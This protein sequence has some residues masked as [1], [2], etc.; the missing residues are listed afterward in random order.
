[1]GCPVGSADGVWGRKTSRAVRVS[2][3]FFG[4]NFR[5]S[6]SSRAYGRQ[7]SK[8]FSTDHSICSCPPNKYLDWDGICKISTPV[9]PDDADVGGPTCGWFAL[10]VC[11]RQKREA[12]K[13]SNRYGG[14]TIF[15]Q[16]ARF[17]NFSAGYYCSVQGPTTKTL[18]NRAKNRARSLGAGSAYIKNSCR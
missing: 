5:R 13:A 1:L 9:V 6:S 14:Y 11:S 18:A 7:I 15:T 17:P 12:N 16:R 3:L 2:N 4:D 8:L 10:T